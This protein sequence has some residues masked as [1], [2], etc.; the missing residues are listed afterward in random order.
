GYLRG[1]VAMDILFPLAIPPWPP[2][3]KSHFSVTSLAKG[4]TKAQ[5]SCI[6][7]FFTQNLL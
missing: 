6:N 5:W 3:A 1:G 4:K 7:S 2:P